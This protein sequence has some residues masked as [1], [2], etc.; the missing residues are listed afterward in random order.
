MSDQGDAARWRP[1]TSQRDQ[2]SAADDD[3][4]GPLPVVSDEDDGSGF[5]PSAPAWSSPSWSATADDD[6]APTGGF[7]AIPPREEDPPPPAERSPFEPFMPFE[8]AKPSQSAKPSQPSDEP[9]GPEEPAEDADRPYGAFETPAP[10]SRNTAY[11]AFEA[12]APPSRDTARPGANGSMPRFD[13]EPADE[14]PF[15][16]APFGHDRGT[17]FDERPPEQPRPQRTYGLDRLVEPEAPYAPPPPERNVTAEDEAAENDFF[18]SDD[19]PP[20]WDKVVAPAGPP[21]KPGK[22]SSGN[23][24]L[25]DWMRDENGNPQEPPPGPGGLPEADEGRSKRPLFIGLCVL[26]VALVAAGGV[27]ALKGHGDGT[28][29][30]AGG[31]THERPVPTPTQAASNKPSTRKTMPVFKGT[32]TKA[33]GRISDARAGLSY[34]RLAPPWAA[35]QANSPMSEIGFSASQFAV[36]EKTGTEPKHWA[37]LMSAPLSGA[38]KAAYHGPGSARAATTELAKVYEARMFGFRHHKRVLASQ[39]LNVGGHKGWLVGDYLTYRRADTKATGDIVAVAVV[40]T[41]RKTPGV[42]F[43]TVPNTSRPLWPDVNF[44]VH[45]L[46]VP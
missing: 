33:A 4:T 41:G 19:H 23:L 5:P 8:P 15:G 26:V 25:P 6:D 12:P 7:P 21:P 35:P 14:S 10:P 24:R 28:A 1:A 18:A 2:Y 45:S 43:M 30:D 17:A 44:V 36:T 13:T 34:A 16:P 9:A 32:H 42:L 11:G 38:A 3:A 29:P 40:D 37:R 31:P 22:P 46:R 20:M 27:Y 39:P